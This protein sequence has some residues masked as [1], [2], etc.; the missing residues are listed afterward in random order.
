MKVPR[1]LNI[2]RNEAASDDVLAIALA[3]RWPPRTWRS[4]LARA[5]YM[6]SR[7]HGLGRPPEPSDAAAPARLIGS[8]SRA[9]MP[10]LRISGDYP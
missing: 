5:L 6:A 2:E 3:K 4:I 10:R 1:H 9:A 8:P 7:A